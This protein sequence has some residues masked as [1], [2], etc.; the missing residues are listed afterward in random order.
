M[1]CVCTL[2]IPGRIPHNIGQHPFCRIFFRQPPRYG[3]NFLSTPF[4]CTLNGIARQRHVQLSCRL[5]YLFLYP[6]WHPH[7]AHYDIPLVDGLGNELLATCFLSTA[8]RLATMTLQF[9][10][11]PASAANA[12]IAAR[13]S[14]IFRAASQTGRPLEEQHPAKQAGGK[15]CLFNC[16]MAMAAIL[17]TWH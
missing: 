12:A 2:Q 16:Y 6:F 7:Q 10:A 13:T 9:L 17:N 11:A 5:C 1:R 14:T 4:V 8:R 15:L 3:C